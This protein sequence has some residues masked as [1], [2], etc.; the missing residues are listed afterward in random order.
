LFVWKSPL[1]DRPPVQ[2]LLKN[3]QLLYETLSL[4]SELIT[5]LHW[6]LSHARSIGGT[7]SYLGSILILSSQLRL[8]LPSGLLLSA[9]T[10]KILHSLHFLHAN[11][12]PNSSHPTQLHHFNYTRRRIQITKLLVMQLSPPSCHFIL[13]LSKYSPELPVIKHLQ[14]HI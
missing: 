9:I 5:A 13:L 3:F 12:M 14:S 6:C 2:Q 7:S 11:Y 4:Y 1:P 8:D 10:T